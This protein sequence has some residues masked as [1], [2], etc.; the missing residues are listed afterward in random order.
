MRLGYHRRYC[1]RGARA[2]RGTGGDNDV[3]GKFVVD[4]RFTYAKNSDGRGG[5][6]GSV[7]ILSVLFC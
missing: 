3:R 4:A 6:I 1:I 2:R 7:G 5:R